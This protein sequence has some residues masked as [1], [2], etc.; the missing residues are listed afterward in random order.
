M[1]DYSRISPAFWIKG[2]G[3]R[4]R[5]D[6][7]AQLV[8]LYLSTCPHASM[9]GIF[10][11]ALPTIAHET[12]LQLGEVERCLKRCAEAKFAWYDAE[13]EIV[14][15]PNMARFQIGETI[16]PKDAAKR[17]GVI[18]ALQPFRKH[19]FY[20]HFVEIYDAPFGLGLVGAT[21]GPRGGLEGPSRQPCARAHAPAPDTDLAPEISATG[22]PLDSQAPLPHGFKL[23]R[24]WRAYAEMVPLTDVD[25]VWQKFLFIGIEKLWSYN[26]AGWQARWQRFCNDERNYQRRE[27]ERGVRAG[28]PQDGQSHPSRT[29]LTTSRPTED[30]LA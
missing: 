10:Y 16:A 30:P 11:L 27:R 7:H 9:V 26:A 25:A 6:P 20:N 2:S 23:P 3:R 28:Q 29:K 14:W 17:M 1:R 15:V 18:N 8:A 24:E 5:G 19:E 4:L 12:G 21:R 22:L 13:A